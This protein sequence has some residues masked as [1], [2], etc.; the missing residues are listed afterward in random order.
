M[1]SMGVCSQ[2]DSSRSI[3]RVSS[4]CKVSDSQIPGLLPAFSAHRRQEID[5]LKDGPPVSDEA[6]HSAVTL[7]Q[8]RHSNSN[9]SKS[10]IHA[11]YSYKYW[12]ETCMFI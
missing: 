3:L 2:E 11:K 7:P 12:Y 5:Q 6:Q 8:A 9:S 10:N 1:L 4:L